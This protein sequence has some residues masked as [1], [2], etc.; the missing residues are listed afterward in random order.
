MHKNRLRNMG[1]KA[2]LITRA[3]RWKKKRRR[4]KIKTR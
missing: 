2:I 1:D 4:G 3:E